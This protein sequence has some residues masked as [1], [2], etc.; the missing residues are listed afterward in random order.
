MNI[1]AADINEGFYAVLSTGAKALSGDFMELSE[2]G[3]KLAKV[4]GLMPTDA[5]EKLADSVNALGLPMTAAGSVADKFFKT[6]MLAAMNLPQLTDAMR[7]AG[8]I[9]GTFGIKLEETLGILGLFAAGGIKGAQ[10]GTAFKM[11]LTKLAAPTGAAA[12]WMT[13]LK[14][15]LYDQ[16]DKM[17]PLTDVLED[18]IK[19]LSSKTDKEKAAAL[20]AIMG[21]EIQGKFAGLM[22]KDIGLLRD[23]VKQLGFADNALEAAFII[24]MSSGL[25]QLGKIKQQIINTAGV[26]GIDLIPKINEMGEAFSKWLTENK[27]QIEEYGA[28]FIT[29]VGKAIDLTIKWKDEIILLGKVL[30]T[31]WAVGKLYA[32]VAGLI[33]LWTNLG[34]AATAAGLSSVTFAGLAAE[35]GIAS[36][37]GGA[38]TASLAGILIPLAAISWSVYQVIKALKILEEGVAAANLSDAADERRRIRQPRMKKMDA[39]RKG[40]ESG[41]IK[42]EFRAAAFAKLNRYEEEFG[43]KKTIDKTEKAV[44][45]GLDPKKKS[46]DLGGVKVEGGDKLKDKIEDELS[47]IFAPGFSKEL[48]IRF[49]DFLMGAGLAGGISPSSILSSISGRDISSQS[50]A[51]PGGASVTNVTRNAYFS[52]Y[53]TDPTALAREIEKREQVLARDLGTSP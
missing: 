7:E 17:R 34:I 9:S 15:S 1:A 22:T 33:A 46:F 47:R 28:S 18:Y 44:V 11:V 31:I 8:P 36:V 19:A 16:Y 37:A 27:K 4:S 29:G 45:D 6:T 23:W 40:L 35:M 13:K 24:K 20:T 21:Q 50:L 30:A 38:L 41:S 48:K 43:L 51:V 52:L 49:R 5:I 26:I 25:E 39:L 32:F 53:G 14:V 12:E 2:T 42:P 3:L 10:A